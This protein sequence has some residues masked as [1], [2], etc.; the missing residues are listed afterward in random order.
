MIQTGG[1]CGK[2]TFSERMGPS[3][4]VVEAAAES[5]QVAGCVRGEC[6]VPPDSLQRCPC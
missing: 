1:A 3:E 6:V 4:N 5:G 2:R